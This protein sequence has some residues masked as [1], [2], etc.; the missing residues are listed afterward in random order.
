MIFGED[1]IE[2]MPLYFELADG[3]LKMKKRERAEGFLIGAHWVLLKHQPNENDKGE[4]SSEFE[5]MLSKLRSRLLR[6]FGSLFTEKGDYEEALK[7]LTENIYLESVDKGP[8]H[9]SLSGS[10]FLMGNI[11]LKGNRKNEVLSF[12]M[13]MNLIWKKF[14]LKPDGKDSQN[15]K[16]VDVEQ[17][18]NE[19]NE[20][21]V[22]ITNEQG[23]DSNLAADIRQT[24]DKLYEFI[25][26][27]DKMARNIGSKNN[28][29]DFDDEEE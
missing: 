13:Q 12:Y 6:S 24:L 5:D 17:A 16:K 19:L 2:L 25:I 10:Y 26:A 20:V 27:L 28:I 23:E 14:L 21:L 3:N 11:F 29:N 15:I 18:C 8:E 4:N 22:Y 7:S 1:S 9:Y